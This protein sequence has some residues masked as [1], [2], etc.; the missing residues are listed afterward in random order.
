MQTWPLLLRALSYKLLTG[1]SQHGVSG[2]PNL[3]MPRVELQIATSHSPS[4]PIKAQEG[5]LPSSPPCQHSHVDLYSSPGH[6]C[7]LLGSHL[8]ILSICGYSSSSLPGQLFL[9]A[10]VHITSPES[11]LWAPGI[12]NQLLPDALSRCWL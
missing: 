11:P 1:N 7:L 6:G 3:R 9:S 2:V 4:W 5:P 10:V 12:L 8:V